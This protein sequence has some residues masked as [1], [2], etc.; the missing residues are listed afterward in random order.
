MAEDPTTETPT[1]LFYTIYVH[2]AH[3]T[4]THQHV[5]RLA[6]WLKDNGWTITKDAHMQA[7]CP[8]PGR[9]IGVEPCEC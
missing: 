2:R 3:D 9:G 5:Q 4:Q 8:D 7:G 6:S 1:M